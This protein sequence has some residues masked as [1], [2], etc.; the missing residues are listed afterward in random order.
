MSK[1]LGFF[2]L[3][4]PFGVLSFL[5]RLRHF[6]HSGNFHNSLSF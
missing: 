5:P 6:C 4:L 3:P 1:V 2:F